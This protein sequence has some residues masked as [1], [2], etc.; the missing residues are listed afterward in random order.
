M[1]SRGARL[2]RFTAT[3]VAGSAVGWVVHDRRDTLN[4]LL[5]GIDNGSNKDYGVGRVWSF[6]ETANLKA[7]VPWDSNWDKYAAVFI[8]SFFT[9]CNVLPSVT[10]S[11]S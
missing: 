11:I 8:I 6:S 9:Q 1:K 2:L 4:S 5:R 10:E 7:S 3:L